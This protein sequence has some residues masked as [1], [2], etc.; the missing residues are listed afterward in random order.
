MT[1]DLLFAVLGGLVGQMIL[2]VWY[3]WRMWRVQQRLEQR[4]SD[5]T[6][7]RDVALA[8]YERSTN[9]TFVFHHDHQ[10][11]AAEHRAVPTPRSSDP[12]VN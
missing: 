2:A 10:N 5:L 3:E 8:A 6:F 12:S 11:S 4:L 7:E 1:T 9:E